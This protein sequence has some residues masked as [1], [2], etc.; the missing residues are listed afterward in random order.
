MGFARLTVSTYQ[1]ELM[2]HVHSNNQ[3]DLP[4]ALTRK[5]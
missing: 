4:E 2:L 1:E 3:F 5:E